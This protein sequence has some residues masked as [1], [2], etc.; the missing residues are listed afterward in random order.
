[1]F[2]SS[3]NGVLFDVGK[4]ELVEF[5]EGEGGSYNIPDGVCSILSE[6][7]LSSSKLTSVTIPSSVTNIGDYAFNSCVNLSSVVLTA[8]ITNIGS[9]AFAACSN[10]GSVLALGNAPSP[11]NDSTV[12]SGANNA[13]VY[14]L[15]GA[16]GWGTNFDGRPTLLWNP[17]AQT[18][19]GNFGVRTNQFGFNISGNTNLT[20][21]VEACTNLVN[22]I[23]QPVQTN[24]LTS[25]TAYFSD[26]QW[27][28]YPGRF[29]RLRSP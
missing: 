15:P 12:F 13:T 7:F 8:G 11:T 18:G 21:V 19:D 4:S 23:W 25:G 3:L 14:Y 27:T 16:T 9:Y 17:Q 28:N 20:I 10:L 24:T 2:Y 6:A 22:P 29:Y 1:M 5:P 26:P